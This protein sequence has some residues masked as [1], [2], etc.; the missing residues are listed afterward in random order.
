MIRKVRSR[1]YN[2]NFNTLTGYFEYWGESVDV[3]PVYCPFG[4]NILDIEISSG[5]CKGGCKF[6]YKSNG[7][8]TNKTINMDLNLF[9]TVLSKFNLQVLCQVAV[10]ICD[11][12]TNPDMWSIFEHCR[13]LNIVPN[14]TC[15]GLGVTEDIASKTSKLC[16]AV[17]VSLVNK[18]KSYDAI[19]KFTDA[20]MKF[21]NIHYML[22][23]QTYEK[24]FDVLRDITRDSRLSNMNAIVFLQYKPKGKGLGFFDPIL[25]HDK[26][27][28]IIECAL[29][30]N[31]S[32]G[33]DSCSAPPY[34]KHIEKDEDFADKA[35]CVESCESGISSGYLNCIGEFYPCSF[36]E[37]TLGWETG[38][39]VSTV[40]T[41]RDDI[42]HHPRVIAW[43]DMLLK[44]S[45]DCN[46]ACKSE[47]RSCPIYPDI[48]SCKKI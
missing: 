45:S 14:Y 6:C 38:L 27:K 7:S 18:E 42:W 2:H 44:S 12:D 40:K 28:N 5:L 1:T 41:F 3:N 26:Y 33:F 21:V 16:G 15:N 4:P 8:H 47:C 9:K 36:S 29:A 34:L 25:N 10:G 32:I 39:D 11:I 37:N 30:N 22:S 19:K 46:C 17:A 43:R 24:A 23:E 35:R 13:S 48:T 20:G 31:V